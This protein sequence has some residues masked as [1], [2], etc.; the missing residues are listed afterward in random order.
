[1]AFLSNAVAYQHYTKGFVELARDSIAKGRTFVLLASLHPGT[2][3]ELKLG[4][5]RNVS[6]KRRFLRS[7]LL[8]L[9]VLWKPTPELLV[10]LAERV[11]RRWPDRFAAILGVVLDYL[12]WHGVWGALRDNR[13]AGR[14][15]T[16]L[17]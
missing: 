16:R 4:A 8:G 6:L 2:L 9:S 13:R 17:D 7:G 11:E 3:M 1:M 15:M 12:Y 5:F 10:R 14:G